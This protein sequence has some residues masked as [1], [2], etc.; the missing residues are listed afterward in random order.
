MDLQ[1]AMTPAQVA[2]GLGLEKQ[3][4]KWHVQGAVATKGDGLY[5]GLDWLATAMKQ[6]AKA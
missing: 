6:K 5:E 4:R 1:G 3:R 2:K